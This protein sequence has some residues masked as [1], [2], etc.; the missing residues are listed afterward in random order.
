[1][2]HPVN[3]VINQKLTIMDLLYYM[4]GEVMGSGSCKR[5]G[6]IFWGVDFFRDWRVTFFGVLS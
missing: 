1:M 6:W 4:S 2:V 5:C 3:R